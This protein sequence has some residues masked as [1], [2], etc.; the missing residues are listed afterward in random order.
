M[1]THIIGIIIGTIRPDRYRDKAAYW[2]AEIGAKRSDLQFEVI[3]L[4]NY[5][6]PMYGMTNISSD[7][8]IESTNVIAR[9]RNKLAEMDGYI[10][11]TAEYNHGISGVLKN[12]IDHAYSEYNRKPAAF[13]GYGGICSARAIEQLRLICVELQIALLRAAVHIAAEQYRAVRQEG[14]ELADFEALNN[15]A[16]AMLDDLAWWTLALKTARGAETMSKA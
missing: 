2:I 9:W 1:S 14:R 12:A 10:F 4:R 3:D 13:V 16:T 6:L 5:P 11:I 15:R 7:Q 8:S